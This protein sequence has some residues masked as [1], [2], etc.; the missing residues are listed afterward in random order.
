MVTLR[1][2]VYLCLAA[3]F[4]GISITLLSITVI[5]SYIGESEPGEATL[6]LMLG[7][8]PLALALYCLYLAL[9]S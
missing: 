1:V 9:R 2:V 5:A 8:V 7:S 6:G 4:L 3:F